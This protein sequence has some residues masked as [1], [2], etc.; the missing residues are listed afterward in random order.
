MS[1]K[2]LDSILGG[3]SNISEEPENTEKVEKVEKE[4]ETVS[5]SI[6]TDISDNDKPKR[7]RKKKSEVEETKE[8]NDPVISNDDVKKSETAKSF[9]RVVRLRR[10]IVLYRRP[11]LN[12]KM[13]TVSGKLLIK[14]EPKNG[15]IA[16]KCML[17]GNGVIAGFVRCATLRK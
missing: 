8:S 17:P 16:V 4:A 7:G 6:S 14:G 11:N 13:C 1:N 9:N 3:G 12:S 10:N 5:E 2:D 15:F